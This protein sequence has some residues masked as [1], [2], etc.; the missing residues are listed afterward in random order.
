MIKSF[1][2]K[3]LACV[4]LINKKFYTLFQDAEKNA[5]FIQFCRIKVSEKYLNNGSMVCHVCN[6]VV[7]CPKTKPAHKKRMIYQEHFASH[8]DL[9][10]SKLKSFSLC[11][12]CRKSRQNYLSGSFQCCRSCTRA[13]LQEHNCFMCQLN[14][15]NLYWGYHK[16]SGQSFYPGWLIDEVKEK[17]KEENHHG[18]YF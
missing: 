18:T 6:Q 17:C 12:I 4:F 15:K 5:L 3:Q 1:L 14:R 9:K 13:F 16:W 11:W 10:P 2:V 7:S 8:A